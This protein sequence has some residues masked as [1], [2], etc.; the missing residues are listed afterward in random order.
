MNKIKRRNVFKKIKEKAELLLVFN[1]LLW[2]KSLKPGMSKLL[3]L[4][5]FVFM[6][7]HVDHSGSVISTL[8]VK[9]LHCVFHMVSYPVRCGSCINR[10]NEFLNLLKVSSG[11][12][13]SLKSQ[14]VVTLYH[15]V[16][17]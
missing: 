16:P 1:S 2:P 12:T 6:S 15:F 3:R 14:I 17:D 4:G 8:R 11:V 10:L 13:F 7:S 9:V 5:S